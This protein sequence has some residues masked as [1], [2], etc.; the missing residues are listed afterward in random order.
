MRRC[1]QPF[2]TYDAVPFP[3]SA[4]QEVVT[5]EGAK[6]PSSNLFGLRPALHLTVHSLDVGPVVPMSAP[7]VHVVVRVVA[8]TNTGA[9]HLD[10]VQFGLDATVWLV[11]WNAALGLPLVAWHDSWDLATSSEGA[12]VKP[13]LQRYAQGVCRSLALVMLG[14]EADR[15][16][17]SHPTHAATGGSVH[18]LGIHLAG[19]GGGGGGGGGKTWG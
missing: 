8:S 11:P 19:E 18:G 13:S 10:A 14:Q 17:A 9:A 12:F 15:V 4:V 2:I 1:L 5:K 7:A 6:V 16:T 3:G